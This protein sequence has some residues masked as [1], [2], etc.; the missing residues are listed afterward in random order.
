M[1]K[2]TQQFAITK[3]GWPTLLKA[4]IAVYGQTYKK[5]VNAE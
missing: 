2:E 4:M 5:R 1:G 3:I